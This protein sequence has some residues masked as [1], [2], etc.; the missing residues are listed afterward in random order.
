MANSRFLR[1]MLLALTAAT[2]SAQ[3]LAPGYVDPQPV[4]LAA[5]QAIGADRAG[6]VM[7][8]GTGYAG[9]VGQQR[10]NGYDGDWP[11]GEPLANYS[12]TMNWGTR[13]MTEAVG[14]APGGNPAWW[15]YGLGGT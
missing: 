7:M 2:A 11:R 5:A 3:Q 4:L 6:C 15:K 13:T 12:R 10:V 8:T 9:K 1:A 14:R